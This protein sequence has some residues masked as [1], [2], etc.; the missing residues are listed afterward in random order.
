MPTPTTRSNS[1]SFGMAFPIYIYWQTEKKSLD[2]R[3]E[4]TLFLAQTLEMKFC[5]SLRCYISSHTNDIQSSYVRSSPCRLGRMTWA[6]KKSTLDADYFT[7]GWSFKLEILILKNHSQFFILWNVKND[8]W[9]KFRLFFH[10]LYLW[11]P[12]ITVWPHP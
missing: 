11:K 8:W 10:L 6:K 12:P 1:I 5:D 2:A 4:D 9:K 3:L 7:I